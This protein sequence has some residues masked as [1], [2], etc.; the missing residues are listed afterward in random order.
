MGKGGEAKGAGGW[1]GMKVS[2]FECGQGKNVMGMEK[3]GRARQGK[4]QGEGHG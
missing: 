1:V 2:V 3:M 4:K